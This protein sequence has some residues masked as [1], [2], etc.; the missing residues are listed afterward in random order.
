M[1]LKVGLGEVKNA[2]QNVKEQI[3]KND[4][5]VSNLQ[6]QYGE[7]QG[8]LG[9][10]EQKLEGQSDL[11]GNLKRLQEAA[12]TGRSDFPTKIFGSCDSKTEC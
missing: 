1:D 2:Q 3:E 11:A 5:S 8:R 10:L 6:E 9:D 4:L 7:A 12:Q